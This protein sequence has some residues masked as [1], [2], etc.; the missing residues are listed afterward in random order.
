MIRYT[1]EVVKDL[2][3]DEK[4]IEWLREHGPKLNEMFGNQYDLRNFSLPLFLAKG[5][6]L[7]LCRYGD[8]VC[9][10]MLMSLGSP[11]WDYKKKIL[12]QEVLYTTRPKATYLLFNEFIDFGRMRA[13]DIFTCISPLTNI[14]ASN[15]EKLGFEKLETIYQLKV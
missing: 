6:R 15:I 4:L 14:K 1:V 9:G 2:Y 8:E 7:T 11:V 12:R 13:D 3:K 10:I 5:G